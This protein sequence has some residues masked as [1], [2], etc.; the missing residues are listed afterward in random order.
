MRPAER[1]RKPE[2]RRCRQDRRERLWRVADVLPELGMAVTKMLTEHLPDI[3]NVKFTAQME[4][5]LD[6]IKQVMLENIEKVIERG[7]S[8]ESL[9]EKSK[10]L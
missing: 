7:E 2:F 9:Q 10:D 5:K 4:E 1:G 6:E 8:L 3:M